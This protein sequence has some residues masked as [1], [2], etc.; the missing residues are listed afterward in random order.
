MMFGGLYKG[1]CVAPRPS[2][3]PNFISPQSLH[4]RASRLAL[5][6]PPP[7][8]SHA[9]PSRLRRFN[10]VHVLSVEKNE[11]TIKECAGSAP[12]PRSHHTAST[13]KEEAE[14]ELS[15]PQHKVFILGGYG[16]L[17]TSRDFFMDV[18][19]LALDNWTWEKVGHA[20]PPSLPSLP[21]HHTHPKSRSAPSPPW[22]LPALAQRASPRSSCRSS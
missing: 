18:H 6:P 16:G 19:F 5:L 4:R 8:V 2:T 1:K 13:I 7:R 3:Q 22:R 20:L 9:H 14:D 15:L 11:W 12:Q 10:D 17:G 21:A